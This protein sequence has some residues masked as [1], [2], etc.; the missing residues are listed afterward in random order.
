MWSMCVIWRQNYEQHHK[1]LQTKAGEFLFLNTFTSTLWKYILR[2]QDGF[3]VVTWRQW[4]F[5]KRQLQKI[6]FYRCKLILLINNWENAKNLSYFEVHILLCKM[7]FVAKNP[8]IW[9]HSSRRSLSARIRY[10]L[11]NYLLVHNLI[12]DRF[13]YMQNVHV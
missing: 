4:C 11:T 12:S 9:I 3:R 6:Y 2:E 1:S 10:F 5:E 8:T 13:Y 7:I